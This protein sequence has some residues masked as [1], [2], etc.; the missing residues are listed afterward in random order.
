MVKKI[1]K[2]LNLIEKFADEVGLERNIEVA[3]N[4]TVTFNAT[5][6]M[7]IEG[8]NEELP[9]ILYIECS[10]E[11][12]YILG[13]LYIDGDRFNISPNKLSKALEAINEVNLKGITGRFAILN[14][15]FYQYKVVYDLSSLNLKDCPVSLIH[16]LVNSSQLTFSENFNNLTDFL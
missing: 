4:D 1:N 14:E 10:N 8:Y 5:F 7:E 6:T 2:M 12:L 9:F 3:D 13:Y 16:D 11:P 15:K